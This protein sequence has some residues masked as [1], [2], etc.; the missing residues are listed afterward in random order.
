MTFPTVRYFVSLTLASE[1]KQ[2]RR[3]FRH[4]LKSG[5]S[6]INSRRFIIS[7]PWPANNLP[8]SKNGLSVKEATL[9]KFAQPQLLLCGPSLTVFVTCAYFNCLS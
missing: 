4:F 7:S 3:R 6:P 9:A 5:S 1:V 8:D 2:Q